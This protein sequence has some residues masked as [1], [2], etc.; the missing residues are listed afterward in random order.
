[1]A[2][3]V[4]IHLAP[5][6]LLAS[7]SRLPIKQ[8]RGVPSLFVYIV[9]INAVVV[10]VEFLSQTHIFPTESYQ[11]FF[12]PNGIF[13]HPIAS[14]L[15]FCCAMV[16]VLY[17][18]VDRSFS[19][20]LMLLFLIGTAFCGVRGPLAVAAVIYLISTFKPISQRRSGMDYL[21]DFGVALLTP[22]AVAIAYFVGALDRVIA[23]GVWD[24]SSSQSRVLIF[25]V[26]KYLSSDVFWW[27]FDNYDAIGRVVNFAAN[28]NYV[29][30]S[31]VFMTMVAGFPFAL[32]FAFI[33]LF[34]HCPA[35][36]RSFSFFLLFAL[37]IFGTICFS[38]KGSSSTAV[39]LT[40]YWIWRT[41]LENASVLKFESASID[42]RK[43]V[44]PEPV[45]SLTLNGHRR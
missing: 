9:A 4:D 28:T 29:E 23:F 36:L 34:F 6:I 11:P 35:T 22:L 31:F 43:I 18:A 45:A 44:Q 10:L 30:N 24:D 7:L 13:G 5:A 39:A 3:I 33:I 25:S 1:M 42:G 21:I 16:L 14:G 38:S 8:A 17:G 2:T 19:R 40:G 27:G 12:R 20:P 32:I 15:H 26:F 41:K 37:A